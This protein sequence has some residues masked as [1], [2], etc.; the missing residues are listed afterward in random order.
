VEAAVYDHCR[1]PPIVMQMG[2]YAATV[3]I[4]ILRIERLAGPG[5]VFGLLLI[6]NSHMN[7]CAILFRIITRR[8]ESTIC[9]NDRPQMLLYGL[10][11]ASMTSYLR[12]NSPMFFKKKKPQNETKLIDIVPKVTNSGYTF[13]NINDDLG[14]ASEAI[15]QSTPL[16][17]MTYGYARRAA[18]AALH[19]QGIVDKDTYQHVVSIF[20]GLQ[21]QTGHTVEF[22]EAAGA[23][24]IEF[25]QS[26]NQMVNG[27]FIRKTIAIAQGY[28]LSGVKLSDGDLFKAVIDTMYAEQESSGRS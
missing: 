11:H 6:A 24:S 14:K 13:W 28:E 3:L 1:D 18:I 10:S 4:R 15:M 5:E 16:V 7:L 12:S 26:Y 2:E 8:E 19:V 9:D 17:K 27:L 25:M 21:I 22:Q 23:Q 20:K